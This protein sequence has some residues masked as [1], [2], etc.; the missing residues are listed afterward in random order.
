MRFITRGSL[1]GLI[2]LVLFFIPNFIHYFCRSKERYHSENKAMKTLELLGGAFSLFFCLFWFASRKWGF[3]SIAEFL[4]YLLGSAA[5]ILI[6]WIL[7]VVYFVKT[8]AHRSFS[9]GEASAVFVAGKRQVRFLGG[10]RVVLAVMPALLFLLHGI[11]QRY[12]LLIVSSI[13]FAAAHIYITCE[14]IR[15]GIGKGAGNKK[16]VK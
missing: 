6:N 9:K 8:R 3:Y 7:W 12:A 16:K 1:F 5:L 15:S 11:T 14:Y 10:L 13:L 4:C 2:F